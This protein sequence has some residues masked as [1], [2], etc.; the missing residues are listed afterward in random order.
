MDHAT[1]LERLLEARSRIEALEAA[2]TLI[3]AGEVDEGGNV[4]PRADAMQIA[5]IALNPNG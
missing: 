3:V 5:F 4:R 1:A 2:L